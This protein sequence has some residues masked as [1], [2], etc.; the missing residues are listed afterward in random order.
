MLKNLNGHRLSSRDRGR[1]T[2]IA[3]LF[4]YEDPEIIFPN[5]RFDFEAVLLNN[6]LYAHS[7]SSEEAP[8]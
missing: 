4:E 1:V 2:V 7:A 6:R 8:F 5:T 3:E